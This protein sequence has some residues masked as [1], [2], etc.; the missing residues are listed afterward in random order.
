MVARSKPLYSKSEMQKKRRV[1]AAKQQDLQRK[2]DLL[3][4]DA[5]NVLKNN[6]ECKTKLLEMVKVRI[7]IDEACTLFGTLE[8][9]TLED[10]AMYKAAL[11]SAF[12]AAREF[13]DA[14][15]KW[16]VPNI[17]TFSD[18]NEGKK[19]KKMGQTLLLK[20]AYD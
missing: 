15:K 6:A 5:E 12:I 2:Q 8:V 11:L 16:K 3:F 17:G 1:I 9:A 20:W 19:C 10:F 13:E 14:T 7:G 18:V 4:V